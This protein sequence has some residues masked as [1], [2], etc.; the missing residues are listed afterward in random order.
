[1]FG[2]PEFHNPVVAAQSQFRERYY[3]LSSAAMLEDLFFDSLSSFIRNH[4]PAESLSR[5]PRGEKGYDYE[6][7]GVKF[8]HKVS[9]AGPTPI[10]AL[11]DATQRQRVTWTFDFPI[12]F[13]T[14]GYSK[15]IVKLRSDTSGGALNCQAISS[16]TEI[17][18][19]DVLIVGIWK[20][21]NCFSVEK[22]FEVSRSGEINK[23]IPFQA[24]W[25][26]TN[27]LDPNGLISNNIELL[28]V[29][30]PKNA[31]ISAGALL[32]IDESCFR[33]GFFLF[34]QSELVD[35]SVE[36]NNRAV[37]V[38]QAKVAD[39]MRSAQRDDRFIPMTTWFSGYAGV[40]PPDLYL[41][42]RTHYDQMFSIYSRQD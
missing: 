23:V 20:T 16:G 38:P 6:F 10:A 18:D 27:S 32:E 31:D 8:S 28:A 22:V 11:W 37:L 40:N 36:H 29:K 33:P 1:M 13:S 34:S 42:Q 3:G 26:E 30:K 17:S 39:L 19:G 24:I 5:P 7:S 25:S 2:R 14:G 9:K 41:S 12:C 4:R 35:V 15:K 21:F